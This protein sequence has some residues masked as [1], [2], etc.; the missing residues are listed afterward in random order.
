MGGQKVSTDMCTCS[1]I[2]NRASSHDAKKKTDN[3]V[4][5]IFFLTRDFIQSP[6]QV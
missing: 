4:L 1:Q 3:R 2:L 6:S 5:K